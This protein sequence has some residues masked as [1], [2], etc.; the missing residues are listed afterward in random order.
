MLTIQQKQNPVK[1][2]EEGKVLPKEGM[3]APLSKILNTKLQFS[4]VIEESYPAY[5]DSE[6]KI[7]T[8]NVEYIRLEPTNLMN[9]SVTIPEPVKS[10]LSNS[11]IPV[12]LQSIPGLSETQLSKFLSQNEHIFVLIR[13]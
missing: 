2:A 9:I 8:K 12:N 10:T 3:I 11:Y 5:N 7:D 4:K 1:S 13:K 6:D